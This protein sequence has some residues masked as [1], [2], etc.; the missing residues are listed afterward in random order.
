VDVTA[1]ANA[2][3]T[4]AA[5]DVAVTRPTL[6]ASGATSV[7]RGQTATISW[8]F[9]DGAAAPV[10]IE[11]VQGTKVVLVKSGPATAADGTGSFAYK[12]P[13]TLPAGSY[14]LRIRPTLLA[15]S[16]AIQATGSFT[17]T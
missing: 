7:V 14:T 8:T 6:A 5:G 3:I 9:S 15:T 4:D 16:S 10:R 13:T 12:A 17:V 1:A 11:L 2:A